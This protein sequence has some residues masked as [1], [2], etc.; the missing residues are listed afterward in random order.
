MNTKIIA[1]YVWLGGNGELRSKARTLDTNLIY[2]YSDSNF[3]TYPLPIISHLP[4]WNYDGSYTGQASG[5]DSEVI[6]KPCS[7]YKCPFR[8]ES[9]ILVMCDTYKPN[10]Q[11]LDSNTRHWA[12]KLFDQN[13]D[14]KPC[15]GIKQE[16]F[17][18]NNDTYKPLGLAEYNKNIYR[19]QCY[20]SVGSRNAFGREIVDMHYGY[21]LYAGLNI[22]GINADVEPGQWEYQIGPVEGIYAGDQLYIARYILDRI[23]EKYD[24][25]INLEP[26]PLK[27]KSYGS[28]C[29]TNYST[30]SMREKTI[31]EIDYSYKVNKTGLDYIY[32]A[33]EK[34]S[35]KHNEHMDVYGTSRCDPFT[36]G[37]ANHGVS[38]RIPNVTIR[39]K[40]GYFEDRRPSSNMDP[41]LV[42]GILFKT[43]VLD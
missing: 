42:T 9:N 7:V 30:K 11:P 39:D 2:P 31:E 41:Y 10:G 18:I 36:Y 4:E 26:K 5:S 3:I 20:C 16:F 14:E 15:Y 25:K 33:I 38:I 13:L 37:V 23:S 34:L 27:D 1:E 28:G 12:K 22:S 24:V 19:D 17:I 6:I 40:R 29:H 8:K 35:L 21:C 32:E 43:T